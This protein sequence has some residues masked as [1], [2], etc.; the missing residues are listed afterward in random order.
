MAID[1]KVILQDLNCIRQDRGSDGSYPYI[2]PTTVSI[3]RMGKVSVTG[4][5]FPS[6]ARVILGNAIKSGDTAAIPAQVGLNGM[7]AEDDLSN[8]TVLAVVA[9][10]EKRD[11]SDDEVL[12][13]YSVFADSLQTAIE[14][15]LAS[16]ASP[17]PDTNQKAI[18]AINAYVHQK[19]MEAIES[20]MTDIEKARYKVGLFVPDTVID[21]AHI[22]VPTNGNSTFQLTFGNTAENQANFY[23]IDVAVELEAV[24]CEAEQ[25]AVNQDQVVVNQLEAQLAEMKKELAQAPP[26]EKPGILED[27]K[28]FSKTEL[29]P[30]VSQLNRA[31]A[32]L[33]ACQAG[34]GVRERGPK[35]MVA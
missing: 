24:T 3:T 11:L 26:A 35:E 30:A 13:G 33:A 22:V 6:L 8:Y 9:L 28:E 19:V 15:N 32:T 10:L 34:A 25:L 14:E 29:L 4:S 23:T 17:D 7:R 20:R 31:K 27:I 16:L 12:G 2:W 1:V 5:E 21:T 18:D